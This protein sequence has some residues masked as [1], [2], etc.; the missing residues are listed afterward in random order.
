MFLAAAGGPDDREVTGDRRAEAD[1]LDQL[2]VGLV[3]QADPADRK[4]ALERR[5]GVGVGVL[6]GG[7]EYVGR[8]ELLGHLVVLDLHVEPLLVPVDQLLHRARQVLVGGDHRDQ[9]ADVEPAA[10]RQQAAGRVEEEG[11]QLGQEVVEEFHEELALKDL[12]ADREDS[13]EAGR[14]LGPLVVGG[15]VG[16]DFHRAVDQL[17]D[18]ARELARGELAFPAQNQNAPP[19]AR[20]DEGLGQDDGGRDQAEPDALGQDEDHGGQGL[21]AEECRRH[22]GIADEAAQGLHLVL[23]HGRDLGLLD[24]AR[25]RQREAQQA[26]D[27]LVAQAAQHAL[28]H[29]ALERVD[30]ELEQAVGEDQRQEGEAQRQEKIRLLHV[31]TAEQDDGRAGQGLGEGQVEGEKGLGRA[32]AQEALALDPLVD[33]RLGQIKGNEIERQGQGDEHQDR[34]L[35]ALAVSPDVPENTFFHGSPGAAAAAQP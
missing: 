4:I 28:A 11:R 22:E 35:L 19:Q 9:R 21:A 32:F 27:Q 33:D 24:P 7:V 1:G 15:V 10:D 26:V 12:V 23:D 30:H 8:L 17:A 2:G 29:A 34:D 25:V 18:P 5:P 31:E 20:N 6:E 3:D 14:D 13:A 16:L